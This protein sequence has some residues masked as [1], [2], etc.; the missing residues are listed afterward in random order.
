MYHQLILYDILLCYTT[1]ALLHTLFDGSMDWFNF[2][3]PT[4]MGNLLRV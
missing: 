3:T 1:F 2:S 4:G